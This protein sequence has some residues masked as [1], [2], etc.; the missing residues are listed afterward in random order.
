MFRNL[1]HRFG[2]AYD[3]VFDWNLLKFGSRSQGG[4]AVGQLVGEGGGAEDGG[5]KL[6]TAAVVARGASMQVVPQ[7]QDGVAAAA[8]A[9]VGIPAVGNLDAIGSLMHA[10]HDCLR[11]RMQLL[12]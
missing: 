11:A 10:V 1:F 12:L 2:L 6:T 9:A 7:Q 4:A 5:G 3:F 8:A